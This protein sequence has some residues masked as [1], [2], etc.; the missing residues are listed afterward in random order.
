[1]VAG[2][3]FLSKKSFN[4]SNLSNQKNVWEK[5]QQSQKEEQRIKERNKQLQIE[6]DHEELARARGGK[7]GGDMASLRFM[8]DAPPGLE[9]NKQQEQELQNGDGHS[10]LGFNERHDGDDDAAAAFR[11]LLSSSNNNNNHDTDDGQH[12]N[13]ADSTTTATTFILSGS[14]AEIN[15]SNTDNNNNNSNSNVQKA[16]TS[17]TQL[18]KAVGKRHNN[19]S[20]S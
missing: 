3:K 16:N 17:L 8:Y 4:P 19:N 20:S 11:Q 15:N 12:G 2:L 13:Y 18:E 7:M 14:T 10:G 9:K 1:M 6:R 5:E